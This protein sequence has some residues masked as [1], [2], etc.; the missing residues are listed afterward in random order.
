[1]LSLVNANNLLSALI[2]FP[3]IYPVL[4]K[5]LLNTL[6]FLKSKERES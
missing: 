3:D 1:M 4:L 6:S 2:N 5:R